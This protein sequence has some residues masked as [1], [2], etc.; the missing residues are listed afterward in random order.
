MAEQIRQYIESEIEL[1]RRGGFQ[2][3]YIFWQDDNVSR[4]DTTGWTLFVEISKNGQVIDTWSIANGQIEHTPSQG[5]FNIRL[6]DAQVLAYKFAQADYR[7]WVDYGDD[8]PQVLEIG[9]ARVK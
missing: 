8:Y 2:T 3:T 6:T 1:L 5:Q 9:I 7:V 4:E